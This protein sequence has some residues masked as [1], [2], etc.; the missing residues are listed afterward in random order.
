ME[1]SL[2]SVPDSKRRRI[3][4]GHCSGQDWGGW[5]PGFLAGPRLQVCMSFNLRPAQ[6][7]A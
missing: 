4:Q 3:D 6:V 1:H 2:V 5:F 7:H